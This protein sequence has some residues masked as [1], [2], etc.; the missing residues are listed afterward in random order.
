MSKA[1][2]EAALDLL[3]ALG[4]DVVALK[5]LVTDDLVIT[6]R[7]H[8][9]VSGSRNY[10]VAL[11]TIGSF[12]LL[13]K[14]GIK[15]RI[16]NLTAEDDR[17]ACEV[18]GICTMNDGREYNNTYHFLMFFRDG[19]LCRM[20]EYLDTKLADDVLGPYLPAGTI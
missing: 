11:A 9:K 12:P 14:D 8:A 16:L 5:P 7:G 1:N 10:E 13:T 3:T 2:K 6:T 19:K 20:N 15:F 17:V 18:E 4:G